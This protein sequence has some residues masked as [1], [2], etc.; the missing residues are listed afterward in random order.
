M[1]TSTASATKRYRHEFRTLPGPAWEAEALAG[2]TILVQA[3]Q[4]L[5]DT[6]QLARYLPLLAARGA[7]VLLACD[8]RLIPLLGTIPEL[9]GIVAKDAPLPP[10]DLWIDQMSLPL[11][12][13]TRPDTIPAP[14]GY[15]RAEPDRVARWSARLG[16]G[17][18]VGLVWAG[19]P[20]HSNDHRRSLPTDSLAAL[21]AVDHVRFVNLQVGPRASEATTLAGVAD[22]SAG[23]VDY[24]ETAALVAAL[25]LVVT[26][27]TSVAHLAG[28]LGRPV[29]VLLPYAPDWRWLLGRDDSP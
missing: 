12:L 15:L 19:N 22:L 23:L 29:W 9:A 6:I 26:V 24:A 20:L 27:D 5:G 17:R 25:D 10:Y 2:R 8:K 7:R 18:K 21:L 13:G 14:L 28:A 16:A 4:G 11:R 1:A 3:E